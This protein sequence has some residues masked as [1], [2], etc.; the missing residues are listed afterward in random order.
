[1]NAARQMSDLSPAISGSGAARTRRKQA[2]SGVS[3]STFYV[4]ATSESGMNRRTGFSEDRS[5]SRSVSR[6]DVGKAKYL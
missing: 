6:S 5:A 2:F 1:M 3:T 4:R